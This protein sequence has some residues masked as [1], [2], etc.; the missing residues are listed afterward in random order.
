MERLTRTQHATKVTSTTRCERCA[1]TS[2]SK[3]HVMRCH[4]IGNGGCNGRNEGVPSFRLCALCVVSEKSE[5]GRAT[6]R[7]RDGRSRKDGFS[8]LRCVHVGRES[9]VSLALSI[10]VDF[11]QATDVPVLVRCQCRHGATSLAS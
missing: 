7:K 8:Q 6:F 1:E 10:S 5:G 9:W 11:V 2:R 3:Q 4:T